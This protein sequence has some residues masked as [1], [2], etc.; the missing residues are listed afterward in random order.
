M[1]IRTNPTSPPLNRQPAAAQA[2]GAQRANGAS[3]DLDQQI[4]RA[5]QALT[6]G[7]L[8]AADAAKLRSLLTLANRALARGDTT[9]A[10]RYADDAEQASGTAPGAPENANGPGQAG[11]DQPDQ[12]E[13]PDQ[14]HAPTQDNDQKLGNDRRRVYQDVS[15]DPGVSF[16]Q[17]T[18]LTPGQ[19]EIMVR[20][21]ERQHLRRDTEQAEA[22]GRK[23]VYAYTA[24]QSRTD[25]ATGERYVKGG[26]TVTATTSDPPSRIDAKA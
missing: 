24:I 8:S 6:R 14:P 17:P 2:G 4:N 10:Q 12:P 9:T 1:P 21:H 3:P 19:A 23:V 22:H 16:K 18:K 20:F 7:D 5:R 13:N 11:K 26:K 15:S 25:P